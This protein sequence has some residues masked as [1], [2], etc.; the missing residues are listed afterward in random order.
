MAAGGSGSSKS[1]MD[2]FREDA[3]VYGVSHRLLGGRMRSGDN[4]MTEQMAEL[5]PSETSPGLKSPAISEL[6][7]TPSQQSIT[8]SA[9]PATKHIASMA[10]SNGMNG[11]ESAISGLTASAQPSP[12]VQQSLFELED[13]SSRTFVGR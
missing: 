6:P 1:R 2:E 4:A 5:P 9:T 10:S 13:S 8:S 11:R 7:A 3:H 12:L